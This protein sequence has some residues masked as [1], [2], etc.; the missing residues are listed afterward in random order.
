MARKKERPQ[1]GDANPGRAELRLI[2]NLLGLLATQDMGEDAK[3]GTLNAAGFTNVE[4][5][6][7]LNKDENAIGVALFR[8]KGKA[9]AKQHK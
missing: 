9:K 4:I 3:V 2:A 6:R 8:Y 1:N 5:A 7:L